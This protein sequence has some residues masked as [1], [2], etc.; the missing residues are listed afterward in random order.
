MMR[1]TAARGVLFAIGLS[2]CGSSQDPTSQRIAVE[3]REVD[4]S[5]TALRVGQISSVLV[6]VTYGD[7]Q[8]APCQPI[9]AQSEV[10]ALATQLA[11]AGLRFENLPPGSVNVSILGHKGAACAPEG[12]VLCGR[13]DFELMESLESIAVPVRCADSPAAPELASC[14]L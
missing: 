13:A 3:L 14:N 9:A 5:C 1:P 6:R 12:L 10:N 8:D 4:S 2:A 7:T 11:T